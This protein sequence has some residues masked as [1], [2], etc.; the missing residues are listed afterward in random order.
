MG[1]AGV[2]VVRVSDASLGMGEEGGGTELRGS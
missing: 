1:V 2:S